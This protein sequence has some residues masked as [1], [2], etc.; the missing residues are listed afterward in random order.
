MSKPTLPTWHVETV[1]DADGDPAH[2]AKLGYDRF[3]MEADREIACA[4]DD[5][6]QA[7]IAAA[8]RLAYY[9]NLHVNGMDYDRRVIEG[10]EAVRLLDD[11]ARHF[12]LGR[13]PDPG[14]PARG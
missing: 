1:G 9:L 11:L 5:A 13:K 8:P 14:P 12:D 2:D 4:P 6:R 10:R 7:L 3:I